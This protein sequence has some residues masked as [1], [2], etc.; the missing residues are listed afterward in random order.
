MA[1]HF[2]DD[3][4]SP[5]LAATPLFLGAVKQTF[6]F[7]Q[8]IASAVS[9]SGFGFW[10]GEDVCVEFRPANADSGIVFVRTDLDG[11]PRIPADIRFREE[12]PRQTSLAHGDAR[13]DMIEHLMAALKALRIDN[14]EIRVDRPEMPGF[15][16]SSRPFFEALEVAGTITQPA[17]R[18]IRLV[19]QAGRVGNA[20]QWIEMLPSRGGKNIFQYELVPAPG[21]PIRHQEY[22]FCLNPEHF[23]DEMMNCRTFLAKHEADHLREHGFCQRVTARDV[24]VLDHDGGDV[25]PI[26]NEFRCENE[27]VRHKILDMV[28]DF[29]LSDCDWIGSFRSYR[30]GHA[31][32]AEAVKYLLDNTMLFD[33]NSFAG[34]AYLMRQKQELLRRAA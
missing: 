34:N 21:Y 2:K 20:E 28:G 11:M 32:N 1:R 12:K 15:D 33:E 13:V 24:L 31:L 16:G 27:C 17:F 5:V 26:E 9:L 8:T 30:G 19:T 10:T 4:V 14:C 7:Q 29:A 6:R 23:R 18:K 3:D 25:I 22:E